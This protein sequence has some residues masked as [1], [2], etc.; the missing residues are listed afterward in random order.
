MHSISLLIGYPNLALFYSFL[1]I[2]ESIP[3]YFSNVPR[4]LINYIS[5]F[6]HNRVVV[7]YVFFGHFIDFYR[8][9]FIFLMY[10]EGALTF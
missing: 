1:F 3:K 9:Y 6:S 5:P 8:F 10:L 7:F 2:L 4:R